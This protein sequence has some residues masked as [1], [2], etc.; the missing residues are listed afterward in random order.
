VDPGV[1]RS[2]RRLRRAAAQAEIPR[3]KS[4]HPTPNPGSIALP[5]QLSIVIPAFNEAGRVEQTLTALREYLP[6]ITADF[7]I[8]VVDD[9][10]TDGTVA[11][12][13]RVAAR[14]PRVLCQR[15]PHRG[16][17]GAVRAGML[18]ATG[19]LRFLCD[20]DL[21]MPPGE[22]PRFLSLVPAQCDIAIGS[23]EGDGALRVGEPAYRH[24]IGR[25]F[26]TA[27][28]SLAVKGLKDTQCGFK[29]F[30]AAAVEATF[31][32]ITI[33][34]WAFDVEV[35]SIA[36]RRG[37][38][39]REVPIEWHYR[40]QSHVSALPDSYRMLRDVLRIRRNAASGVYD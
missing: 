24:V 39:I 10:S 26:N 40:D 14:D 37:L 33:E 13:E 12:V 2:G 7:E 25:V 8:R 38:R 4:Q 5:A 15:E 11:I 28:T 9:G 3:P 18:A 1:A 34:G 19:A 29:L 17:G 27:V 32:R 20:A 35:L 31:P 6:Q 36:Q 16:K 23:R 21:S 22:L 30:T